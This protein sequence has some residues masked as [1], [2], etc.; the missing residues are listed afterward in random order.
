MK[1]LSPSLPDLESA[2]CARAVARARPP[3]LDS[4][5]ARRASSRHSAASS[6]AHHALQPRD[7]RRRRGDLVH[8]QADQERQ[9]V[10]VGA[11]RA[12]HRHAPA[13]ARA[14]HRDRARSCAA[15]PD[16]ARRAA[17]EL[18]MAAIDGERVLREVV[19][20]DGEEIGFGRELVGEQRRGGRLDQS[21]FP[22]HFKL[23]CAVQSSPKKYSAFAV[24]Q[25]SDLKS[26]RLTRQEGRLAIV[27]KRAVGCGGRRWCC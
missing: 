13:C 11:Q 17:G 18:G 10:H 16:A 2:R 20:A 19:G 14:R 23:I 6:S 9:R 5:S 21:N 15:P 1:R 12:A 25:I 8:A 22:N 4:A 24:G 7:R 26:A 27:T 3:A